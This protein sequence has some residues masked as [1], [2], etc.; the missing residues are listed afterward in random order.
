MD[1]LRLDR[2][3]WPRHRGTALVPPLPQVHEGAQGARA[4]A[5]RAPRIRR[6][7]AERAVEERIFDDYNLLYVAFTRPRDGLTF[8]LTED[9]YGK[10]LWAHMAR[11]YP[12]TTDHLQLGE[13]PAP[14]DR[15]A[16]VLPPRSPGRWRRWPATI[17]RTG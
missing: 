7:A 3:L 4:P 15:A 12:G 8:Y 13:W 5:R 9:Y 16:R 2:T 11:T 14:V 17:G 10:D 6:E 1:G